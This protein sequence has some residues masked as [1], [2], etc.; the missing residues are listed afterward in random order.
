MVGVGVKVGSSVAVG[1]RVMVGV[2]VI[3]L[4]QTLMNMPILS[5]TS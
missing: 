3:F 2:G 5:I 1:V 4:G